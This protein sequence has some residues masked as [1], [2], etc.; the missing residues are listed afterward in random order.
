[1][2]RI[3]DDCRI[4]NIFLTARSLHPIRYLRTSLTTSK[5]SQ[6]WSEIERFVDKGVVTMMHVT[7]FILFATAARNAVMFTGWP[8]SHGP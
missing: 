2:K 3:N 7:Y 1:M 8:V 4:Q 6:D 5:Q